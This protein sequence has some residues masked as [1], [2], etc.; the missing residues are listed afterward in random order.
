MANT[1][2]DPQFTAYIPVEVLEALKASA[3]REHRSINAQLVWF[4]EKGLEKEKSMATTATE[5]GVKRA[6]EAFLGDDKEFT[7]AVISST[8]AGFHGSSQSIE[9]FE[10]GT[11]RII[12]TEAIGS[13]YQ[14]TGELLRVP[15]L[16]DEDYRDLAQVAGED[17]SDEKLAEE[18]EQWTDWMVYEQNKMRSD[19]DENLSDEQGE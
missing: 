1:N 13:R 18:L 16:S 15:Q 5:E 10:D 6:L 2:K 11:Y 17:A 9:L 3:K 7:A 14:P 19:L 12:W 4:L 8:N